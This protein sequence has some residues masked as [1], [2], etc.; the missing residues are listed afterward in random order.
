M[1]PPPTI[2]LGVASAASAIT[3]SVL[4]SS[5][6]GAAVAAPFR[7]LG[8]VVVQRGAGWPDSQYVGTADSAVPATYRVQFT[9]DADAFELFTKGTAGYFRVS[10][11]GRLATAGPLSAGAADGNAYLNLVNFGSAATREVTV[12]IIGAFGGIRV[13]PTYTVTAPTSAVPTTRCVM[14]GDSFTDG[15]G[16][17]AGFTSLPYVMADVLGW[18]MWAVG[19]GGTGYT[20][21]GAFVKFRDRV[22][23]DVI[24]HSPNVVIVAG[25]LNDDLA[26]LGAEAA[27][28]YAAIRAGLPGSRLIVLSPAAPRSVDVSEKT[29]ALAAAA[30]AAGAEYIDQTSW[31]TGTGDVGGPNGTG[32]S[33]IYVGADHTHPTQA[34]HDYLG[35]RL[36]H[37]IQP[38]NTGLDYT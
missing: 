17:D 31:L 16:A 23:A 36:A 9:T 33:D 37:A 1:L 35:V 15:T 10:V 11:A 8:A 13:G 7:Y 18:D 34:G 3:D 38:P 29:A 28:L 14:I 30:M 32:N 6:D 25:G 4:T 20:Q 27:L 24:A 22:Q 26:G 2:T 19:R 21:P 5:R 12:E